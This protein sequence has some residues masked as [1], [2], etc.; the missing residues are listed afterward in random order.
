M[1]QHLINYAE[2]LVWHQFIK[3]SEFADLKMCQLAPPRRI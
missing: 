1:Y 2:P 3:D